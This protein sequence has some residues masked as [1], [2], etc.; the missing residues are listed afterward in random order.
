MEKDCIKCVNRNNCMRYNVYYNSKYCQIHKKQ[1]EH[2]KENKN[3][4]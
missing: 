1:I 4:L 3:E 2:N